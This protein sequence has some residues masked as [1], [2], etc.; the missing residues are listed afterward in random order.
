MVHGHKAT[1]TSGHMKTKLSVQFYIIFFH[2]RLAFNFVELWFTTG[3]P[4]LT[5]HHR[6]NTPT[7]SYKNGVE[8]NNIY[9]PLI[10]LFLVVIRSPKACLNKL[11]ASCTVC[12]MI[13]SCWNQQILKYWCEEQK[14]IHYLPVTLT[15]DVKFKK[16]TYFEVQMDTRELR[17]SAWNWIP[18]FWLFKTNRFKVVVLILSSLTLSM[19]DLGKGC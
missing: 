7:Y 11:M 12:L 14:V 9:G 1:S 4:K 13:P 15:I 3:Q 17:G 8:L 16:G 10:D 2:P 6:S 19:I 18:Q 5:Y